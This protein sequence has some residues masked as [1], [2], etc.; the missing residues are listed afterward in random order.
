MIPFLIGGLGVAGAV[1]YF[2]YKKRVRALEGPDLSSYGGPRPAD[3]TPDPSGEG[4]LAL[5]QYLIQRFIE[6]AK[7]KQSRMESLKEKR[8]MFDEGGLARSDPDTE[9]RTAHFMT[10]SLSGTT[11]D[12][13]QL[14]GEWTLVKGHDPNKRLLYLHGGGGTVGSAMSHRAI[15]TALAKRTKAAVFAPNYR[16]MPEN[17]RRASVVDCRAAYQWLLGTSPE[18]KSAAETIAV[19]GDSAGAN[20]SLCL[21]NGLRRSDLR[22]ADAVVVF[23]APTDSTASSPSIKENFE[24]DLML[25]PLI[26]PFLKLPRLLLL[27]GLKKMSGYEPTDPD[28]SP[29]HD[30]LSD[31]PPTLLQVSTAEMLHDDSVR[32]ANKLREAGSPVTLQSW[33]HV[34]HVF[35]MFENYI[36]EASHALDLSEDFLNTHMK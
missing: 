18:D 14:D 24:T 3:F 19:A 7:V 32:Y 35:Q 12:G 10:D 4:L 16:L 27:S 17:P 9:Y 33:A 1:S 36:E 26:K 6:P 25:Q 8:Q 2:G 11:A 31:L 30:D 20:L 22:Q 21:V 28:I 34:P 5:N 29:I 13:V 23:S 15:T